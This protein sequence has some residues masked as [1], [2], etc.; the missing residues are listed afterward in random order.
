M[1]LVIELTTTE[2]EQLAAVAK[3]PPGDRPKTTK[4]ELGAWYVRQALER[5]RN[6]IAAALEPLEQPASAEPQEAA[7]GELALAGTT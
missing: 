3:N 5:D 4:K 7:Q 1:R 2:H 6:A